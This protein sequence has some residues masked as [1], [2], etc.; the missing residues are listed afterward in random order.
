LS[1]T[2]LSSLRCF[3]PPFRHMMHNTTIL[4]AT[5]TENSHDNNTAESSD[6]D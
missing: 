5:L 3:N 2:S 4:K 6:D 1:L